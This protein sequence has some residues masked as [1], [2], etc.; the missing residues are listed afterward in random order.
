MYDSAKG[1]YV[2]IL[3]RDL[4]KS[5]GF[6]LKFKKMLLKQVTNILMGTQKTRLIQVCK[7][8]NI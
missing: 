6:N 5:L 8:L 3:A 7:K 2:M 4:L 1:R